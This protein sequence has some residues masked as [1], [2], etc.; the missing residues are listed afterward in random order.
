MKRPLRDWLQRVRDRRRRPQ[1]VVPPSPH[2]PN[3]VKKT[4]WNTLVRLAILLIN[5]FLESRLL[6]AKLANKGKVS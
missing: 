3:I 2:K 4:I 6:L 1:P 5:R